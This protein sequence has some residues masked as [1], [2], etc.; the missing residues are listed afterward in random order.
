MALSP[1]YYAC[2][3]IKKNVNIG[4]S[5]LKVK[6]TRLTALA[7]TEFTTQSGPS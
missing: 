5:L 1:A 6:Y 7:A 4:S 2:S 3:L